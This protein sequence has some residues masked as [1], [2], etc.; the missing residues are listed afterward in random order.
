VTADDR[1]G[2]TPKITPTNIEDNEVPER[3]RARSVAVG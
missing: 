2:M 3:P 1:S